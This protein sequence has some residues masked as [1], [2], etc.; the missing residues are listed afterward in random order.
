MVRGSVALV[1]V[2]VALQLLASR[3]QAHVA[4]AVDENNR[5]IKVSPMG[6]RIQLAF[7][8]FAGEVPG[9]AM[10]D[11]LPTDPQIFADELAQR[12][13][14]K[15][16][17]VVGGKPQQVVWDRV[18]IDLKPSKEY[19]NALSVSMVAWFCTGDG[20]RKTFE[21]RDSFEFPPP[22]ESELAIEPAPGV[23]V[24]ASTLGDEAGKA[25]FEWVG[26]PSPL[27]ESGYRLE[28]S[29]DPKVAMPLAD[30]RCSTSTEASPDSAS[31]KK[32]SST[33]W[34]ALALAGAGLIVGL[35]LIVA[36][37]RNA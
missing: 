23:S 22:G 21:L 31:A 19:P 14:A 24:Q 18:A 33:M 36:R 9:T 8:V 28:Y 11:K 30:G 12:V 1:T 26:L 5:Y 25:K 35:G 20:A 16:N 37:K 15:L 4:P 29:A 32:V 2:M 10:R 7:V 6:D 17:V 13:A 27:A 3:A 34:L